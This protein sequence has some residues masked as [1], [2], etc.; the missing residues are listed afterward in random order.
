MLLATL[1]RV[2]G[3]DEEIALPVN[4]F[5]MDKKIKNISLSV[6]ASGVVAVQNIDKQTINLNGETNSL[7]WFKLKV[8]PQT[9]QGRVKVIATS[10]VET[11][12]YDV[13]IESRNANVEQTQ[14]TETVL[15][16]GQ[17]FNQ[18]MLPFG[19]KGTNK[20]TLEVSNMPAINLESRLKYLIQ[21]PYGCVEQTTSSVFPQLL[22]NKFI[23][24]DEN[25]K[26]NIQKNINAG[27]QKLVG[28]Q[29]SNGGL[30]YWQGDNN[31]NE[32]G[33]NYASHFLAE[34][35]KNGYVVPSTFKDNIIKFQQKTARSWS[36]KNRNNNYAEDQVQAYRLYVLA[37]WGAAEQGAMNRLKEYP[38][39]SI[40]AA[41]RLAGAYAILGQNEMAQKLV[42]KL[43]FNV[44]YS[45]NEQF[46][47]SYYGS[48]VRDKAM[49]LDV[50]IELKDKIKSA[51]LSKIVAQNLASERYLNTQEISFSLLAMAKMTE[52]FGTKDNL[53]FNYNFANAKSVQAQTKMPLAQVRL[54]GES[55][56]NFYIKN[57][58]NALEYVRIIKSGIPLNGQEKAFSNN[59]ILNVTYTDKTGKPLDVSSLTQGT[60]FVATVSVKHPGILPSYANLALK[61]VF[62]SGWEISNPRFELENQAKNNGRIYDF[63]DVRDDRIYTFFSLRPAETKSFSVQLTASY[64]GKYYLPMQLVESMY[65]S[66]VN[67]SLV[68]KWVNVVGQEK[69]N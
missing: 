38:Q 57:S 29:S 52:L 69:V 23:D 7:V 10:G 37:M 63:Q 5:T 2:C 15:E 58:S 40:Q 54:D 19:M 25:Q 35:E 68:G 12:I 1:P 56:G 41:W 3:P 62:P 31:P 60:S 53:K 26:A 36:P 6:H 45:Q 49:I 20:M 24:L 43:N 14:V 48:D 11:A 33:T 9:G 16:A 28:F 66:Q 65:Q 8:K 4:I 59:I 64:I 61:Q 46:N 27:I 32:W 55:A 30:S 44:Q 42:S 17:V 22:L 18:T 67:A 13:T 47:N 21:Y 50:M 34:A 51:Q 39:L